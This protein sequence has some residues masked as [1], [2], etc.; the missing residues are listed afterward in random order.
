MSGWFQ[1]NTTFTKMER[2]LFDDQT[3][4]FSKNK[5]CPARGCLESPSSNCSFP[6]FCSALKTRQS[7]MWCVMDRMP[8]W[9]VFGWDHKTRYFHFSELIYYFDVGVFTTC[10]YFES[11]VRTIIIL[12][13]WWRFCRLK[14]FR[15]VEREIF[16]IHL[17][18][19]STL[20]MKTHFLQ[21]KNKRV[22]V[23]I[24]SLD[25]IKRWRPPLWSKKS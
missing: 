8:L 1:G 22:V 19:R 17:T 10:L 18:P 21:L 3:K 15:N 14:I 5:L 25:N 12:W 4:N 9:Y 16:I 6:W 2:L 13:P 20:K 11:L 23:G 7:S 24:T